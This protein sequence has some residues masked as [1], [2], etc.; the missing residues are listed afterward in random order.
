MPDRI[1]PLTWYRLD[2]SPTDSDR[3]ILMGPSRNW[4]LLDW[5]RVQYQQK[6]LR[7]K[8]RLHGRTGWLP[9]RER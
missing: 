9:K 2:R 4:E 7:G 8:H 5:L 1:Y 6:D 3:W